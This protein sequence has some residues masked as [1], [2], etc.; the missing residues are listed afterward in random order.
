MRAE[1]AREDETPVVTG[2]AFVDA[3]GE[4]VESYWT[5]CKGKKGKGKSKEKADVKVWES[6]CSWLEE[7]EE[8]VE[9]ENLVS[10]LFYIPL[11]LSNIYTDPIIFL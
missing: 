1:E 2:E 8:S 10:F 11:V 4:A 3:V 5:A 6:F 9:D 7:M